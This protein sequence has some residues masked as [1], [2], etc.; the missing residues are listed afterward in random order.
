MKNQ[1]ESPSYVPQTGCVPRTVVWPRG[2]MRCH[3][4]DVGGS[5]MILLAEGI[6]KSGVLG[7]SPL[8]VSRMYLSFSAFCQCRQGKPPPMDELFNR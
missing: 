5:W 4:K 8:L 1:D 6:G 7:G 3:R 2:S